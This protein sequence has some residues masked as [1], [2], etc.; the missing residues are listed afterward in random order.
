[1]IIWT[2]SFPV[3]IQA[4]SGPFTG[5]LIH[6]YSLGFDFYWHINSC[7]QCLNNLDW[8]MAFYNLFTI[9]LL[10]A[11][12][13]RQIKLIWL[14]PQYLQSSVVLGMHTPFNQSTCNRSTPFLCT[15][16]GTCMPLCNKLIA[17]LQ[18]LGLPQAKWYMCTPKN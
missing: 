5:V 8:C 6:R 9:Y 15:K 7:D 16:M 18:K 14:N 1:M 12:E 13:Y 3:N 4:W 17:C 11:E 10:S 2:E